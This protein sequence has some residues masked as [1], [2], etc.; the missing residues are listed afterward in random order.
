MKKI[1]V[2][3]P[4]YNSEAYLEQCVR[5]LI[6]Q[7]YQDWEALLIDDGSTDRSLEICRRSSGEDGRIK[8]YHQ[9]NKG[10]SA[11]RNNGLD[12]AGGEYIYF[13]DSDDVVHP[14]LFEEM[15]RQIEE[16]HVEMAF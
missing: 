3:V 4:V 10:A 12:I 5:S 16:Y 7:T 6:H 8:V 9:E 14:H 11:A 1:S 15:I 2:I 13:L